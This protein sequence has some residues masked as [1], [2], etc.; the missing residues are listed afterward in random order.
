MFTPL[1]PH[2]RRTDLATAQRLTPVAGGTAVSVQAIVQNVRYTFDGS[3]P[4]ATHGFQLM[5]GD[6]PVIIELAPN[7]ILRFIEEAPTASLHYQWG[8]LHP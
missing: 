1:G 7:M 5:A 2:T 3:T 4:A 8:I 6:P